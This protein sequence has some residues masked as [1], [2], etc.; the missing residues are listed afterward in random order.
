MRKTVEEM[1]SEIIEENNSGKWVNPRL[2]KINN[3]NYLDNFMI[4]LDDFNRIHESVNV[5]IYSF[6]KWDDGFI[7][8]C[9]QDFH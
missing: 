1:Y 5:S 6:S 9:K 2:E 7:I 4:K 8:H 3:P